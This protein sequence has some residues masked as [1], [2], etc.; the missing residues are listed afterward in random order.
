M[1]RLPRTSHVNGLGGAVR[2]DF[3]GILRMKPPDALVS[4]RRAITTLRFKTAVT[5][6]SR[7]PEPSDRDD[8]YSVPLRQG[9]GHGE[10]KP[11]PGTRFSS[12]VCDTV[13]K[14][15][16][17]SRMLVLAR[18]ASRRTPFPFEREC[19]VPPSA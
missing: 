3:R 9:V 15:A 5:T 8:L 7:Q 12:A 10:P 17:A 2:E 11:R 13:R 16:V 19:T 14:R 18:I 6:T 1:T 4:P